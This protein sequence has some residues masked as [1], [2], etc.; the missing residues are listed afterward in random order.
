MWA[1]QWELEGVEESMQEQ[2]LVRE[3]PT[4]REGQ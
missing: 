3:M 1:E 4:Q 2:A